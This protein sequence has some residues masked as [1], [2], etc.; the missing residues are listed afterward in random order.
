MNAHNLVENL[1]QAVDARS[2]ERLAEFLHPEL[3]FRFGNADPITGKSDV[4]AANEGFFG[5]IKKMTHQIDKIWS[6]GDQVICHG[7]VNYIR[8]DSS[9]YSAVF[10]TVLTLEEA[11][12]TDYLIYAD[13]SGL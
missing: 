7:K 11:L 4:L 6:V 10:A 12:I 1:Y 13:V 9:H 3:S 5:S 2:T 8:L